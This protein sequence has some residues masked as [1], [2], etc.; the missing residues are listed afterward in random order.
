MST[1][2]QLESSGNGLAQYVSLT[3]EMSGV[4]LDVVHMHTSNWG[5][6]LAKARSGRCIVSR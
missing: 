1:K 4:D 5:T 6:P 2:S 3:S